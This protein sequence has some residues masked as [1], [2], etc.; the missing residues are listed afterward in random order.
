VIVHATERKDHSYPDGLDLALIFLDAVLFAHVIGRGC[1][2]FD[3]RFNNPPPYPDVC[4]MAGYPEKKNSYNRFTRTFYKKS[5]PRIIQTHALEPDAVL[6]IGGNPHYHFAVA[7]D[8]RKDFVDG[9]TEEKIPELFDL[10]GMSGGGVWNM[11]RTDD[12]H[13]REKAESLAGILIEDR[14]TKND[15]QNMAKVIK[16]E[17]VARIL[18]VARNGI[19]KE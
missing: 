14:D 19:P 5:G 1:S 13:I 10:H 2:F 6:K 12:K 4:L 8:K 18:D 7:L 16:I 9:E 11:R 15:R 17:A 3:L